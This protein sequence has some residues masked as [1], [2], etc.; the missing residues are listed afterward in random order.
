MYL[1]VSGTCY[2]CM[3]AIFNA[4][5]GVSNVEQGFLV[6]EDRKHVEAVLFRI[7][8]EEISLEDVIRVHLDSH[9]CTSNHSFRESYPSAIYPTNTG[10]TAQCTEAL[11]NAASDYAKPVVTKVSP[12]VAFYPTPARQQNYFWRN[13]AKPFCRRVIAPKMEV[14][15]ELYPQLLSQN[16]FDYLSG[17]TA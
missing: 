15:K 11:E 8:E 10:H 6:T 1:A 5:K 16:A 3:E 9:A 14:L 2:W 17:E 12:M 7:N 13:P 4:L